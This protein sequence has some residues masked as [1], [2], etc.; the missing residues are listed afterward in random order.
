MKILCTFE[1]MNQDMIRSIDSIR[2]TRSYLLEQI[3]GLSTEQLNI[4]PAGFNNNIIWNLGHLIAAQ[5]SICY[6]RPGIPITVEGNFYE[7]YKSGSKPIGFTGPEEIS[8]VKELLFSTL[9]QLERDL[10]EHLFSSFTPW[11]TRYG[12]EVGN[13][14]QA[15]RF[16]PYHEGLHAGV[17]TSMKK[18][19]GKG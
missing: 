6:Y 18:M 19:V 5:Q 7:A 15:I 2:L 16:L 17:I 3:R 14:E 9:D 11:T 10:S 8:L 1:K 13:I 4:I 12:I